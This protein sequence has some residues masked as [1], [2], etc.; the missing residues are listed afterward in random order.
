MTNTE[1]LYPTSSSDCH[2]ERS[3]ASRG[4]V[5][6]S[7]VAF[8]PV[9]QA[10]C[11][12][13]ISLLALLSAATMCA[14]QSNS[15]ATPAPVVTKPAIRF[16]DATDKAGIDFVHNFGSRQLGSLLEGTGAGCVWIDY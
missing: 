7:A 4:G 15:S 1:C 10:I 3:L 11:W 5:E 14:A 8:R 12:L 13:S 9:P 16:E 6:G 2:P